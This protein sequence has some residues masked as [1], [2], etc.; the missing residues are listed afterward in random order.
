MSAFLLS[1]HCLIMV[2][3]ETVNKL[4]GNINLNNL[5]ISVSAISEKELKCI[6]K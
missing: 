4:I 6:M 3:M 2:I 5:K 1:C